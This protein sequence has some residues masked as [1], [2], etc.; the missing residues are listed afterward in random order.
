MTLLLQCIFY[1]CYNLFNLLAINMIDCVAQPLWYILLV[2]SCLLFVAAV[3]SIVVNKMN[4]IKYLD[5]PLIFISIFFRT[6]SFCFLGNLTILT[7]V[8]LVISY[9]ASII[10]GIRII[11]CVVS[12]FKEKRAIHKKVQ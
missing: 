2:G 10:C 6:V 4:F 12:F 3:F 9:I 1:F 5:F 8:T 7:I 11:V